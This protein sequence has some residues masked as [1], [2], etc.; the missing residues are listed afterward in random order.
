MNDSMKH[1]A[2]DDSFFS[3]VLLLVSMC[4]PCLT[5]PLHSTDSRCFAQEVEEAVKAGLEAESKVLLLTASA[6]A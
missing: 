3:P 4:A 5:S 1:N 2:G 6:A